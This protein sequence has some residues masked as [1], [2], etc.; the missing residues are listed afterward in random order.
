MEL[1]PYDLQFALSI[2]TSLLPYALV[3]ASAAF[4]S[5]WLLAICVICNQYALIISYQ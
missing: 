3:V 1:V 4:A 2:I 5:H